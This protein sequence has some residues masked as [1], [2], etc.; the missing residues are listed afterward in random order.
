MNGIT[1]AAFINTDVSASFAAVTWLLIEWNTGKKKP[2][3]IGL[4]TGAVAGLATITPAAGYVT[5]GTAAV[6]GVLAAGVCFMAVEFKN[7]MKWD[8]ALDVWGVHGM[9]GVFGTIM[10]GL[11]ASNAIN[12]GVQDGALFGGSWDLFGKEITALLMAIVWASLFTWGTLVLINKFV[13]VKVSDEIQEHGLDIHV[14][15][16]VAR[17]I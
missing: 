15:G 10:L 8:D 12:G 7:Y 16:E 3:F 9:G 6:I 17:A 11:V 13:K 4:M 5:V 2:T 14:H 1:V